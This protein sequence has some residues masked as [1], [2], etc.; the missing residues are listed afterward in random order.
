M[1]K[2]KIV[3]KTLKGL[4]YALQKEIEALGGEDI[5]S[6]SRMVSFWGDKE[7]LYKSNLYLG[8]ALRILKPLHFAKV[9]NEEDIYNEIK[10]I[11]WENIFSVNDTFRIDSVVKST[12]FTHSHYISLKCKDAIVDRFREKFDN[13]PSI[14]KK[15]ADIALNIHIR[16]NRLSISLDT[17]GESLHKRG[18]K[19]DNLKA[20]LNEVLANGILRLSGWEKNKK[21]LLDPMCGSGTILIEAGMMAR[22]IPPNYFR[23]YFCFMGYK[24]FDYKLFNKI[25]DEAESKIINPTIEINGYDIDTEAIN[26]TMK[27]IQNTKLLDFIKVKEI[28]FFETERT[29]NKAIIFNPPYGKRLDSSTPFYKNIGRT[30]RRKYKSCDIWIISSFLEGVTNMGLRYSEKINLLN[31]NLESTLVNYEIF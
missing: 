12:I 5:Q 11:E 2:F 27:N 13:R 19:L 28:D 23:D 20:P 6:G 1:K 18:Y 31:G 17:S 10:N 8:T 30:L 24:N 16:E 7:I 29:R 26:A 3:A 15:D 14:D 21:D 9:K 22:N 4:E 25:K